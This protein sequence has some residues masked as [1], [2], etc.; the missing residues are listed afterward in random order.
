MTIN[1]L[2]KNIYVINLKERT[3]RKNH[4]I[5][6]LKKI[7]CINYVLFDAIDG[8]KLENKTKLNSGMLGLVNT[9]LNI[10]NEWIKNDPEDILG[11]EYYLNCVRTTAN[12]FCPNCRIETEAWA[13]KLPR[14]TKK[15]GIK[16]FWTQEKSCICCKQEQY[17]PVFIKGFRQICK[18]CICEHEI[19]LKEKYNTNKCLII[20]D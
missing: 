20:D 13:E 7:S 10:Y 4:I 14:L 18:I 1:D 9:Y 15:F 6:E 16:E 2:S 19:S 12:R 5:S 11:Q 17:N 8:K 3:D